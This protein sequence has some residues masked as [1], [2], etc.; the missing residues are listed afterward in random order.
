MGADEM[1]FQ[2]KGIR[3]RRKTIISTTNNKEPFVGASSLP[4]I[5]DCFAECSSKRPN[6]K[7]RQEELP[8]LP[9][10]TDWAATGSILTGIGTLAGAAAVAFA[11]VVGRQTFAD[12]KRQKKE[13]RR[14][15]V[16]ERILTLAYELRDEIKS[17]RAPG[18]DSGEFEAAEEKLKADPK[19]NWELRDTDEQERLKLG[20]AYLTRLVS[21]RELW[22]RV[23]TLKPV[24]LAYFGEAVEKELHV[25]W[26]LYGKMRVSARAY[27]WDHG[28]DEAFARRIHSD[29]W[30]SGQ[31]D[32]TSTEAK[33]AVKSLEEEL[34]TVLRQEGPQL[35]DF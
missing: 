19:L 18:Y 23:W 6:Y 32:E 27:A 33:Q 1:M 4:P 25:F 8:K 15:E 28:N 16:A 14:M 17:V 24:A 10:T 13:E 35:S 26:T 31:D 2:R 21:R 3:C 12:W 5:S 9:C 22:E 29:L 30:G 20:Q 11:A 7:R 34:L